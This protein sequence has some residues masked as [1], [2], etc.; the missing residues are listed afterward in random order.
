MTTSKDHQQTAR[1]SSSRTDKTELKDT[2]ASIP[3]DRELLIGVLETLSQSRHRHVK[4]R[5]QSDNRRLAILSFDP[6]NEK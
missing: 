1:K 6:A 4:L 5:T 3:A 2:T